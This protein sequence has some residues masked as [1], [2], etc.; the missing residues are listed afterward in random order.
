MKRSD[1]VVLT[2]VYTAH[3]HVHVLKTLKTTQHHLFLAF[4]RAV[5]KT[6]KTNLNSVLRQVLNNITEIQTDL[7]IKV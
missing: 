1:K 7:L 3:V 4:S 2:Q 6:F 5:F